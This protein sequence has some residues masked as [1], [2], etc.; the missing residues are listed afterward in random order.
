MTGGVKIENGRGSDWR[1]QKVK[2]E[3][4]P[5]IELVQPVFLVFLFEKENVR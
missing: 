2:V 5:F 1:G 4:Q 3:V